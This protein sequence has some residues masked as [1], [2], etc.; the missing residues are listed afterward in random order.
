M[1]NGALTVSGTALDSDTSVYGCLRSF[2]F[3]FASLLTVLVGIKQWIYCPIIL[4]DSMLRLTTLRFLFVIDYLQNN[5]TDASPPGQLQLPPLPQ[6]R[7]PYQ[8]PALQR[9][10]QHLH[11]FPRHIHLYIH[12]TRRPPFPR[13]TALRHLTIKLDIRN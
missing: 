10:P 12:T 5:P 7:R 4:A 9:P 1:Q 8:P 13:Q 11:P 2:L 6:L 3:G